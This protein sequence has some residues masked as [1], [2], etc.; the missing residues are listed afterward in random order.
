MDTIFQ[1]I[2]NSYDIV[3]FLIFLLIL[4]AAIT[5]FNKIIERMD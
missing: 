5:L 1:H 4:S 3:G 2:E